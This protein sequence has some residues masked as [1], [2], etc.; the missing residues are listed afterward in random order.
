MKKK[1]SMITSSTKITMIFCGCTTAFAA[2]LF[3]FLFFFPLKMENPVNGINEK[4]IAEQ[5]NAAVT[6]ITESTTVTTSVTTETTTYSNTRQTTDRD[7]VT[8]TVYTKTVWKTDVYID[9]SYGFGYEEEPYEEPV[10]TTTAVSGTTEPL[11]TDVTDIT[12][13]TVVTEV[14]TVT[15]T[16][17]VV[18]DAPQ[19]EAPVVTE[20]PVIESDE[21]GGSEE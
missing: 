8:S 15:D 4:I 6:E 21:N 3:T 9:P 10:K 18:T 20:A 12:E 2:L 13:E 16:P 5:Q 11:Q 14:P 17:P 19:T 1:N 7:R